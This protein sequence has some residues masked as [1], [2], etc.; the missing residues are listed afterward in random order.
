M[1]R[2]LIRNARLLD[3]ASGLDRPGGLL[4]EAGRIAGL[5]PELR[6]AVI[7]DAEVIDAG[8]QC[9]APGLVDL[10]V[11]LGEPGAEHKER[12]ESAG[13][14]AV[15]GG[16][17]SFAVLPATHPP[18][19]DPSMVEFVARR[20]R[21]AR[22][23]KVYPWAAVTRGLEGSQLSEM[24]LLLEAGAVG[25][26]DGWRAIAE[27]RVMRRALT[28]ARSFDALVAVHPE[29][30]S[31][32]RGTVMNA[33][34][35]ATRLGLA[36]VPRVAELIQIER[37]LRL[38]ETTGGRLHIAH[39]TTAEGVAAIRRAKDAGH[40]VTCDVTPHHLLLNELEVEGYRTFAKVSPPLRGE[41][42]RLALVEAL[43]DGTID[44]IASD[45]CPQDQE[46]KRVPFASAEFGVVG[47]E[48]MLAVT[49]TLVH[50]GRLG[51]LRLLEALSTA[52]ARLLG[53]TGGRL[54]P[55]APADLV[56]FD[57][58]APWKVTEQG[59]RS[60]SKNTAFE[61]RLV[62]GRVTRTLVDGRIVFAA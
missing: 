46:S 51:L 58:D 19:D 1:A 42:D 50:E 45:H 7:D 60:L 26:T 14:A 18:I 52:P 15:A 30:P 31:L 33:G 34:A 13:A 23:A 61:G 12:F 49:L 11:Q 37:D 17:T 22:L 6:D 54:Q 43:V 38:L 41:D 5:G 36:G 10:R 55:G 47:L 32:A 3:P 53:I 57:P 59:L 2:L 25:F 48:T 9:L 28:Y 56:V 27:A 8:G 4:V 44:A 24:G 29:E 35:I 62:Q 39:V 40:A 20:A 16:V 21:K